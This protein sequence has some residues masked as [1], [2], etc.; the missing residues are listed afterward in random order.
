M[1]N[2]I[3][4]FTNFRNAE[5]ASYMKRMA[6]LQAVICFDLEDLYHDSNSLIANECREK[7]REWILRLFPRL[8]GQFTE[9]RLGIRINPVDSSEFEK[10]ITLLEELNKMVADLAV[11]LPKIFSASELIHAAGSVPTGTRLI[12]II[13]TKEAFAELG[14]IVNCSKGTC[15]AIA[16][17]HCDFNLAQNNFP[18]YHQDSEEYKSW[19]RHFAHF[20]APE[21]M[22]INSP[23]LQLTI[24]NSMVEHWRFLR[25]LFPKG[26]GQVTLS[27]A[28][29]IA[30]HN[31]SMQQSIFIESDDAEN[32]E[33][34]NIEQY[35]DFKSSGNS[36]SI[37]SRRRLIAP[38]EYKAYREAKGPASE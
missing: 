26:F 8:S 10:D 23:F 7:A 29:S 14:S 11:F 37:N 27:K 35:L 6:A 1:K 16:F 2:K 21:F 34:D 13:E 30:L 15:N 9:I 32:N 22:F 31:F 25:Q 17:G 20:L 4:H 33:G 28:Q 5:Y 38:Q 3:F 12:P 24:T 19:V 36:V 18:F